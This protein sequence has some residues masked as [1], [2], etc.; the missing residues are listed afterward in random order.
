M[1]APM[2]HGNSPQRAATH[3]TEDFVLVGP[4]DRV[5]QDIGLPRALRV[6]HLDLAGLEFRHL[7]SNEMFDFFFRQMRA[8]RTRWDAGTY[9]LKWSTSILGAMR[10]EALHDVLGCALDSECYGRAETGAFD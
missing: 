6:V 2:A 10:A 7:F 8:V 5:L 3:T 4:A 9:I 1:C